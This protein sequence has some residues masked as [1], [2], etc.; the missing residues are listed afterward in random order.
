LKLNEYKS[1]APWVR[2]V[3]MIDERVDQTELIRWR[4]QS[5]YSSSGEIFVTGLFPD[6][7]QLRKGTVMAFGVIARAKSDPAR[8][9]IT[10]RRYVPPSPLLWMVSTTSMEESLSLVRTRESHDFVAS[11]FTLFAVLAVGLA[12]LGVYGIVSHSDSERK[13]E[14]GVR[15]ALG[16]TAREIVYVVI[17]D[18]NPAVLAGVA[19]GLYLIKRTVLWLH[20]FSFDG[21]EY[22]APLF[23]V[24]GLF[25]FA[26]AVVS[27]LIPAWRATKIDPVESLRSE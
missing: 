11:L 21:D 5:A 26:T 24:V 19:L 9:P 22:D 2:V 15:L 7:T 25:L 13:R 18:G 1:G 4:P 27:A 10:L 12:A 23:A 8:L 20:G 3:G 17:R 16:A 6:S 14:L